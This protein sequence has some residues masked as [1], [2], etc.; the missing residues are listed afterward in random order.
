MKMMI[1]VLLIAT[2][3]VL[4]TIAAIKLK[5]K[6]VNKKNNKKASEPADEEK[7]ATQDLVRI[8]GFDGKCAVDMDGTHIIFIH[9]DGHNMSFATAEEKDADIEALS[10]ALAG[11][12]RPFRIHRCQRPIDTTVPTQHLHDCI[13]SIEDEM[14]DINLGRTSLKGFAAEKQLAALGARK[15]LIETIY[16]PLA[17]GAGEIKYETDIYVTLGFKESPHV[18]AQADDEA[19]AFMA[20]LATAGY[21]SR[22]LKPDE[23]VERLI[24]YYSRFPVQAENTN[25]YD[26][27]MAA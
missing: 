24:N 15:S 10:E 18:V 12:G 26:L 14:A 27:H 17:A 3:I 13:S 1:A 16:L 25:P 8:S 4:G 5:K 7:A 2:M 22:I 19:T 23:I 11:V 21:T 20:L 6:P 9:I